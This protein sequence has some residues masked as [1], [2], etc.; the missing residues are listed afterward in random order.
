MPENVAISDLPTALIYLLRWLH[1]FSAIIWI[2]HLYFF[3]LV[4]VPLQGVLDKDAKRVVNPQLL[5]RALWWFRWGA[6][7]TFIFGWTLL[8]YKYGVQSLWK[9]PSGNLSDRAMWILLGAVLGTIMW[10]NVWFIIWPV[11]KR[12]IGWVR[13]GQSPPEM[14][15]LAKKALH[16]SRTNFY[17]SAP[18]LFAMIAPNHFATMNIQRVIGVF[19]FG[20]LCAW[21][22]IRMSANVGKT[23]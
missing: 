19:V 5:P 3:N 20:L 12:I 14:P 23:V 18:M 11:Q 17:L 2:G 8:I 16:A 13:D 15:K 6:M 7:A 21:L 4:N 22:A 1:I 9:D 10:F